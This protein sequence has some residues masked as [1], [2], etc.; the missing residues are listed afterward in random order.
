MSRFHKARTIHPEQLQV[1]CRRPLCGCEGHARTCFVDGCSV[2][3][4]QEP[5]A[6]LLLSTV[7]PF[8]NFSVPSPCF[9][10]VHAAVRWQTKAQGFQLVDQL[11]PSSHP[12]RLLSPLIYGQKEDCFRKLL[13]L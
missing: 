4:R 1:P 3:S 2:Q 5:L 12:L 11:L 7:Q 9:H 8:S 6:K 13:P 10:L